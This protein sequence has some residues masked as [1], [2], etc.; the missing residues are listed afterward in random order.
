[1]DTELTVAIASQQPEENGRHR[2]LVLR[3]EATNPWEINVYHGIMALVRS[4][5][6]IHSAVTFLCYSLKAKTPFPWTLG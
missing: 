4:R 3:I 6:L 1:M 5:S 2:T